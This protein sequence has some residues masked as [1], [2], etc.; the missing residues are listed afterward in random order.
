[1]SEEMKKETTLLI[2]SSFFPNSGGVETTLLGMAQD[3]VQNGESVVVVTGNKTKENLIIDKTNESLIGIDIYRYKFIGFYM[4]YITCILLLLKLK[5]QYKFKTVISRSVPTTICCLLAGIKNVK[6]IAPGV[7]R[8]QNHPKFLANPSIKK[9]IGYIVN[10]ILEK[11]CFSLLDRVYVFSSEMEKQIRKFDKNID[12]VKVF[13]GVDKE[14]FCDVE[15]E[16]RNLLRDKYYIP[17]D[18]KVLLFMCRIEKVKNP[19]SAV[20]LLEYLDEGYILVMVGEGS[21]KQD[22]IDYA[23]EKKLMDKIYFFGFTSEPENFY[24]LSDAF[25]MLSVYEPFGQVIL[26]SLSTK[27]PVFGFESSSTVQ[28]ATSEIFKKLKI[29]DNAY[30]VDYRSELDLFAILIKNYFQK[31]NTIKNQSYE[32]PT[33]YQFVQ[34]IK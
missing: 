22:I 27:T 2:N 8:F 33:W 17:K 34:Y 24:K 20:D 16:K 4:Y 9:K 1:M 15:E 6:Y 26:E 25:L 31:R 14:R 23:K 5:K 12:I 11:I 32:I 10:S 3:I 19:K 13:P 28:T 21:Y 29:K 7:Y 18:K 30:L